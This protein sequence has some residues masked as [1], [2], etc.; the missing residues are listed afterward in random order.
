MVLYIT[1]Q[2]GV[3]FKPILW[4]LVRQAKHLLVCFTYVGS[5]LG[6]EPYGGGGDGDG[7]VG[8]LDD[9]RGPKRVALVRVFMVRPLVGRRNTAGYRKQHGYG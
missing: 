1:Y 9:P 6:I 2:D 3:T 4:F 8:L 7:G 5:L